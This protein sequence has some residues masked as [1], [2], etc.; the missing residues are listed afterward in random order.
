MGEGEAP[1]LHAEAEAFATQRDYRFVKFSPATGRGICNTVSSLVELVHGAR[2]KYSIDQEG[3]TQSLAEWSK[4]IEYVKSH[5]Q[6]KQQLLTL[7]SSKSILFGGTKISVLQNTLQSI[8]LTGTIQ[9]L[10]G[11]RYRI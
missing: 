8:G 4:A 6:I 10:W 7:H 2:D 1:V 3:Y 9:K 5:R 11:C